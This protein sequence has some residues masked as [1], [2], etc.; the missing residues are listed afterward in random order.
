MTRYSS[1]LVRCYA[2]L[3]RKQIPLLSQYHSSIFM[4]SSMKSY[5]NPYL[6]NRPFKGD[7]FLAYNKQYAHFSSVSNAEKETERKNQLEVE[8]ISEEYI[9]PAYPTP[10]HLRMYEISD[11]DQVFQHI[12]S[13]FVYF[14]P[15]NHKKGSD[16]IDQDDF[17]FWKTTTTEEV[18][19]I[20]K[21]LPVDPNSLELLFSKT[22]VAMIQVNVFSCGGIA[23]GLCTSHKIIDGISHATFL[24][25][26][27]ATSL[28][29]LS[30]KIHPSFISPSISPPNPAL[31]ENAT[32][33]FSKL[34][35]KQKIC[36]TRRFQL[37][38]SSI[39]E[40]K[41]KTAA[42]SRVMAVTG[43]IWKCIMT[44]SK[45]Q[46]KATNCIPNSSLLVIPVNL[47]TR[48]IPPISP[49]A[50]GNIIWATQ[51]RLVDDDLELDSIVR[52]IKTSIGRINGDFVEKMKG[53]EWL[54]KIEETLNEMEKDSCDENVDCILVTSMCNS[55]IYVL[56]NWF[57][58]AI[59]AM[60]KSLHL[61]APST[62]VQLHV[63]NSQQQRKF[64]V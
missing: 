62:Q 16:L 6:W 64:F 53:E 15:N 41:K 38:S 59:N 39:M 10:D 11:L 1:L 51:H 63:A 19:S 8:I 9:K 55:G 2:V 54:L 49:Y 56:V 44:A 22:Y 12:Y 37:C 20:H 25:A 4:F 18:S 58:W 26:W 60:H 31:P 48:S 33:F 43:L 13:P 29:C 27:A 40:L 61:W 52:Y 30:R 28:G 50:I 36:A 17:N 34:M 3:N 24:K 21:F 14:Y 32:I 46:S 35:L 7:T 42:S 45:A 5:L 47:R 23:I 57:K